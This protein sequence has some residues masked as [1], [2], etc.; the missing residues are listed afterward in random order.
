MVMKYINLKQWKNSEFI[1]D[2]YY[3]HF[4]IESFKIYVGQKKNAMSKIN[5]QIKN[6]RKCLLM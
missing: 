4:P 6:F 1:K 3:R 2:N 5:T